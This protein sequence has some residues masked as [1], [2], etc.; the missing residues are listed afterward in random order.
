M[1]PLAAQ[2]GM[3]IETLP[4]NGVAGRTRQVPG[5]APAVITPDCPRRA[6][7]PAT[8]AAGSEGAATRPVSVRASRSVT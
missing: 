4:V 2:V 3:M 6:S 8:A 7:A 1:N 5:T